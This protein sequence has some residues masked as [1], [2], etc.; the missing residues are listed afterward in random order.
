VGAVLLHAR[1]IAATVQLVAYFGQVRV[2][3]GMRQCVKHA[4]DIGQF[5]LA[6]GNLAGQLFPCRF[7]LV[8]LFIVDLRVGG[9]G[10]ARVQRHSA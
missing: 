4:V 2:R 9:G 7:G 3:F 5:A 10:Q 8:V 1:S 6:K